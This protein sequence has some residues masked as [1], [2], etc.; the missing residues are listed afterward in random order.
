VLIKP[1]GH[2]MLLAR[3]RS[4]VRLRRLLDEWKLRGETAQALGLVREPTAPRS[5]AGARVLVI[6]DWEAGARTVQAALAR[7]R[8]VVARA[9]TCSDAMQS[10]RRARLDLIVLSLS[11]IDEDPLRLL[12]ALRATEAAV[13]IPILLILAPEE[14]QTLMQAVELGAN[15][16]AV[17][18]LD[19]DELR[20]RAR[21][22][23]LRKLYQDRL[24]ADLGAALE[25]ASSD[26]LT[27]LRNRRW[28]VH[29]LG[30]LLE[31]GRDRELTALLIDVDHFKSVNDACG[32][33]AGDAALRAVAGILRDSVRACDT[34][35][36]YG[37]D[38]FVAVMPDAGRDE[39]A[40]IAE[41]LRAAVELAD[42][43]PGGSAR[44]TVSVGVAG[45]AGGGT[46]EAVLAAADRTLYAAKRTGRNRVVVAEPT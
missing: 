26:P 37:G 41:R 1:I 45:S 29:H 3:I 40:R 10:A 20:A 14:R 5:A 4:L 24:R 30:V 43:R 11:L 22:Q 25:L 44:I 28:L 7:D 6:D 13:A 46:A 33:A 36:R 8:L 2:A 19:D 38:E 42:L 31:C 12:A 35:A 39:A 16:W 21:N 27:G 23:I 34:V 9:R 17:L 32:H 15:D 18:P